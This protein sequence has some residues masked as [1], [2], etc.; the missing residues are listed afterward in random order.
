[1]TNQP[2]A[3]R[4]K[5]GRTKLLLDHP[6]FGVLILRLK[7]VETTAIPTMATD[8]VHLFF[9]PEF[10]GELTAPELLGCLAHEVL[11]PALQHHTRRGTRSPKRWNSAADYVINPIVMD[12]G[13]TLPEGALYD[14]RFRNLS[15]E[16]VYNL[17][18]EENDGEADGGDETDSNGSASRDLSTQPTDRSSSFP[19]PRVPVTTGGFGQV[20]DARDP[21]DP[22]KPATSDQIEQQQMDWTGAVQQAHAIERMAGKTPIGAR[23]AFEA[24]DEAMIDWRSMLRNSFAAA[25]PDDYSWSVPNRRHV[26]SGLY[27][28]SIHKA[29]VGEIVIGVDC[30]GSINPRQLGLF[31]SE[32]AAIVEERRPQRVHVL[33]FDTRVHRADVF[34][35]GETITLDPVGGGGTNFCGCFDYIE[36]HGIQPQALIVFTDLDGRFPEAE[37]LYPVMWAATSA[38]RAPF[39]DVIPMASA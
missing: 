37:P 15:A 39:G 7:D 33:Y 21:S 29:G 16:R 32:M 27:L 4:L 12:A 5:Q 38:H 2:A 19:P 14:H 26:A 25:F 30:S 18:A 3:V 8:G 35:Q 17:L 9:N 11:H 20:I 28:P 23:R 6:F 22:S 36:D 13:L 24:S 34:E 1:M 31:Q 10:V